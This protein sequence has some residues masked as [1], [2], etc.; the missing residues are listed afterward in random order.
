[1][2]PNVKN[3]GRI[4]NLDIYVYAYRRLTEKEFA[5]AVKS[6]LRENHLKKLPQSGKI[7]IYSILGSSSTDLL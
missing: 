4:D 1:M 3:H 7:E 5:L 2:K 6:Y